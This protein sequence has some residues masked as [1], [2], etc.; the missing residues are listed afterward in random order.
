[1]SPLGAGKESADET[2]DDRSHGTFLQENCGTQC[3]RVIAIW[4]MSMER[5]AFCNIK[6]GH[7]VQ[8]HLGTEMAFS[9]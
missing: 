7:I 9:S 1:M 3:P 5:L 6:C 4:R 2:A 8:G